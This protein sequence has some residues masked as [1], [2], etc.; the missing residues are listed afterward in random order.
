MS[1]IGSMVSD[2]FIYVLTLTWTEFPPDLRFETAIHDF[3]HARFPACLTN[4]SPALKG[5]THWVLIT[6]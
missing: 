5:L 3:P 2:S 1:A 4:T 6:I